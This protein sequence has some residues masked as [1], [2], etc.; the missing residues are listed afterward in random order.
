[1]VSY[2]LA[3]LGC[4]LVLAY[5]AET[6]LKMVDNKNPQLV[7]CDVRLPGMDGV[8]FA[9]I[10]KEQRPQ[11]PVLLISAYGPP[12]QHA[13][14]GFLSKPFDN[15][16]LLATVR[17]HLQATAQGPGHLTY[18]GAWPF[19]TTFGMPESWLSE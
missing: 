2:V 19:E 10:V 11:L 12:P 18:G 17:R 1:M 8:E 5:D 15:D 7:I 13:G 16:Q 4:E 6:G 9:T 3:E 14:D